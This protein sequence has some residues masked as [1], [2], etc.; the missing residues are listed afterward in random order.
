MT[1]GEATGEALVPVPG[2]SVCDD[3]R[4]SS[5]GTV[6]CRMEAISFLSDLIVINIVNILGHTLYF[7]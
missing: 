1:R 2:E 4:V 6:V 5:R 7:I 3:S